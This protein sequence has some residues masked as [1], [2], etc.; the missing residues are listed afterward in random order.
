VCPTNGSSSLEPGALG[1]SPNVHTFPSV[2]SAPTSMVI[3][4]TQCL[5]K[6]RSKL[7]LPQE[8]KCQ[9]CR[10]SLYGMSLQLCTFFLLFGLFQFD[11]FVAS[12]NLDSGVIRHWV[13]VVF[14]FHR[15][16]SE[17]GCFHF[18]NM[19]TYFVRLR[20]HGVWRGPPKLTRFLDCAADD[21]VW[22]QTVT[23]LYT[24]CISLPNALF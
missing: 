10:V 2:A 5:E 24:R 23:R 15:F 18:V 16:G 13:I 21:I 11:L 3:C 7:Q 6:W 20:M 9:V 8:K 14:Y 17:I 12:R 4:L 22:Q 1:A 19:V